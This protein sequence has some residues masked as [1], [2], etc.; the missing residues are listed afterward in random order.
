MNGYQQLR[1]GNII[2]MQTETVCGAPG[3]AALFCAM[4]RSSGSDCDAMRMPLVGIM[5]AC[6]YYMTEYTETM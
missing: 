2:G 1:E 3:R 4:R 6:R 5:K